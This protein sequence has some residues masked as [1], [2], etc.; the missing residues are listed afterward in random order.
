MPYAALLMTA[1]IDA[2][3]DPVPPWEV[4]GADEVVAE[5]LA[6]IDKNRAHSAQS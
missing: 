6:T 4:A 2:N 1:S 5:V 3:G